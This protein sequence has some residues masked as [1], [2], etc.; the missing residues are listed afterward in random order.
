MDKNDRLIH[1]RR[2]RIRF[3]FFNNE[4]RPNHK[5]MNRLD[6]LINN[7]TNE[8][9]IKKS[10]PERGFCFSVPAK[11]CA[12][13]FIYL[14]NSLPVLRQNGQ[15]PLPA[16]K[17]HRKRQIQ[18]GHSNDSA[19]FGRRYEK[20]RTDRVRTSRTPNLKINHSFNKKR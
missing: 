18:D 4:N 16:G 15:I 9:T 19:G 12:G 20:R 3:P 8:N 5:Q 2:K 13:N 1:S 11:Q 7:L 17:R 14:P 10:E 6:I